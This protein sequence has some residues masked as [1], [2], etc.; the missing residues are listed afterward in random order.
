MWPPCL[1]VLSTHDA[2]VIAGFVRT[3]ECIA[4]LWERCAIGCGAALEESRALCYIFQR[5]VMIFLLIPRRATFPLPGVFAP[6][7]RVAQLAEHSTLNRQ[8][9][10][11]IPSASTI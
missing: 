7:G 8:V 5:S 11:S 1:L 6:F 9:E 2:V 4:L 10:G 3:E